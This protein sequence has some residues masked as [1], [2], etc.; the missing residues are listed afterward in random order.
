MSSLPRCEG[1]LY[2]T[3]YR[4]RARNN[5]N[6]LMAMSGIVVAVATDEW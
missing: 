4:R 1:L 2:R 6:E 5:S 3:R